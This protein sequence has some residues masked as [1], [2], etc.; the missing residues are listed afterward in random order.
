MLNR[1][2]SKSTSAPRFPAR[3]APT[4]RRSRCIRKPVR[5]SQSAL[6]CALPRAQRVRATHATRIPCGTTQWS[7]KRPGGQSSGGSGS[8]TDRAKL[9][10]PPRLSFHF[11]SP[12]RL[13]LSQ[14]C[15]RRVAASRCAAGLYIITFVV[16]FVG[17]A[18][19][20]AE[21]VWK[22]SRKSQVRGSQRAVVLADKVRSAVSK[23][24]RP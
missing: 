11:R 15:A 3:P 21:N 4:R 1:R 24:D 6:L 2:S 16:L 14:G 19:H 9:S 23:W 5:S 8:A 17:A 10:A 13:F 18:F 20:A 7:R 12:H 22:K